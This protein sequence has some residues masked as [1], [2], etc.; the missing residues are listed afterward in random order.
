MHAKF[1][2]SSFNG[3][4]GEWGD[5]RKEWQTTILSTLQSGISNSSL[6]L[7]GRDNL[8]QYRI[9]QSHIVISG[10]LQIIITLTE[11]AL[12]IVFGTYVFG[13]FDGIPGIQ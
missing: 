12:L 7:L 6:A 8:L 1:Q 5:R 9:I 2:A 4:G 3:V 11:G 10:V 13:K